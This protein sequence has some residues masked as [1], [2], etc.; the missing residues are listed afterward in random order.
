MFRSTHEKIVKS[1]QDDFESRLN[2]IKHRADEQ[3][4]HDE[5]RVQAEKTM[6]RTMKSTIDEMRAIA[7]QWY[8]KR[9]PRDI[10]DTLV[11]SLYAVDNDIV[12]FDYPNWQELPE[13][14]RDAFYDIVY[15]LLWKPRKS[16]SSKKSTKRSA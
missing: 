5:A 11:R 1:L 13:Q 6:V 8:F 10:A 4:A 3:V 12:H 14:Y 16:K 7:I 15:K 2:A 9:D